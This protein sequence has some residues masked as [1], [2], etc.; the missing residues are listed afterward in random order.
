MDAQAQSSIL[1]D[2]V[3]IYL[4][5]SEALVAMETL[6]VLV[7]NDGKTLIDPAGQQVRCAMGWQDKEAFLDLL[8]ERLL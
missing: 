5:F 7:T 2:S 4:A 8:T 6:P 3:A 1:Y